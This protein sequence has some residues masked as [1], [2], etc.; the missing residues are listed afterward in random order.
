MKCRICKIDKPL[1]SE[2][3]YKRKDS[4][5]GF[6]SNCIEC[7]KKSFA[8]YYKQNQES[9]LIKKANYYVEN[10]HD[11][12]IKQ[13]KYYHSNKTEFALRKKRQYH[14][15]INAKIRKNISNSF[16]RILNNQ[17]LEKTSSVFQ[18]IGCSFND[19]ISHLE[20]TK[21]SEHVSSFH[22]DHIIPCSLYDH[23]DENEIKKCWN[24]K[25]LRY[26]DAN[27]NMHKG[28]KLDIHLVKKY[29]IEK[30][31]PKNYEVNN[32]L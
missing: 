21:K 6:R 2:F 18:Y 26:L 4:K 8:K 28:N 11:I 19:L 10:R 29:N 23:S 14:D 17:T 1:N 27:E 13:N 5:K 22:I 25:N 16:R 30:L 9:L 12:R 20:S 3:F 7:S 31:L 32:E 24:W 15:D